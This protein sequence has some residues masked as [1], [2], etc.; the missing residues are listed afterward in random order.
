MAY[1]IA[2]MLNE[3]LGV[4]AAQAYFLWKG[5]WYE[6]LTKFP[7]A[8][9]DLNGYIVF[10]TREAYESCRQLRRGKTLNVAAPGI[11]CI[12]GYVRDERISP[13]VGR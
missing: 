4:G 10:D 3:R 2:R 12:P 6:P 9:F 8:L 7:G 1:P 11:S 5:T 13:L